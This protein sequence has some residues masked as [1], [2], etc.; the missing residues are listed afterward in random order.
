MFIKYN[1]GTGRQMLLDKEGKPNP[2]WFNKLPGE[3]LVRWDIL[4]SGVFM[5]EFTQPT[6]RKIRKGDINY[7]LG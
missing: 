6:E 7:G 3:T 1:P 5:L 2:L 4:P